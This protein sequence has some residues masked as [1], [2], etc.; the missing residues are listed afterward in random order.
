MVPEI[1]VR[2]SVAKKIYAGGLSFGFEADESL[3]EIPY[4][5][6]ATPVQAEL[7]F[8]IFEDDSVEV[9]G[10]ISYV[11]KGLCSRCLGE[12]QQEV[13]YEVE[14]VFVPADPQDEEYSYSNGCVNLEEFLRDSVLFSLPQTILCAACAEE[15]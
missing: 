7:R 11:L 2:N 14:G 15:E 3:L 9:K 1:D 5:V 12:A 6:F 10:R 13:S 8:E 4:T